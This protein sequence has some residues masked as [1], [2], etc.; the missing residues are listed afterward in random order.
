M[1]IHR[2]ALRNYRGVV[3]C[4]IPFVGDGVT[5]VEG[6]NEIGKTSLTEAF[7][8]ALE[9]PDSSKDAR[10][11][12]TQP[13]GQD[14]GP[15]VEIE[16][17][18][19]NYE[20]KLRKRWCRRTETTL[21]ITSPRHE[22]LTG[23]DAHQRLR[24]ILDETLDWGLWEALRVAQGVKLT[25]PALGVASLGAALDH[26]ATDDSA[27]AAQ[28]ALWE[29]IC[30]ERLRY[31]TPTGLKTKERQDSSADIQEARGR[32]DDLE[33][34]LRQIERDAEES[35]RLAQRHD[36][37]QND[38]DTVR[39]S[40][41]ELAERWQLIEELR[42]VADERAA[43][44]GEAQSERNARNAAFERRAELVSDLNGKEEKLAAIRRERQA[45]APALEDAER[46][47]NA[48]KEDE[49]EARA[50]LDVAEQAHTRACEDRDHHRRMIEVAQFRERLG[51]IEEAQNQ[52]ARAES[53]LESIRVDSDL[54]EQIGQAHIAVVRAEASVE[55]AA[56]HVTTTAIRSV[57]IT[58]D[59][60]EYGLQAG[61][62]HDLTVSDATEFGIDDRATVLVR[63]GAGSAETAQR[64]D[65]ARRELRRL[66][67]Q[68]DVT[69]LASAQTAERRRSSAERDR[70]D[71]RTAIRDNLRDL[72]YEELARM[73]DRHDRRI[74]EYATRRYPL[75]A[76]PDDLRAA[77]AL[78]TASEAQVEEC[79]SV[80]EASRGRVQRASEALANVQLQA[81]E[82][83]GELKALQDARDAASA[84]LSEARRPISDEDLASALATAE[85]S[86]EL[87]AEAADAALENLQWEEPDSVEAQLANARGSSRNLGEQ[88][89]SNDINHSELRGSLK[90][91][92]EM[93]LSGKRDDAESELRGLEREHD[94]AE[95]KALAAQCLH[96]VFDARWRE[97]RQKYLTPFREGIERL[98]RI[99]FNPTFEVE[100]N[101]DLGIARRTLDGATLD[102]SQLSTGAREQLGIIARLA[103]AAIVSP[104]GGGAPVILDDALGWSDPSR[105]QRM[106]A[107]IAAAGND[108]QVIILTCTPGRYAYVG[109]ATVV[110]LPTS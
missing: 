107:A 65:E 48:A 85:E 34:S 109:N 71:A 35:A 22:Q 31:W 11:K 1:R 83:A 43:E 64:L 67:D 94:S 74:E 14:V 20:L 105:L 16:I 91:R 99:V 82:L 27:S 90:T 59:E 50:A 13:V 57:I 98:G 37:I 38:L 96:Q 101:D 77:L 61:K 41:S 45:A 32:L 25:L 3:D 23:R 86:L 60:V 97:A 52:L 110:R 2:I 75:P 53:D 92:G 44:R 54:V 12:A 106:G 33:E 102:V 68:G 9:K 62:Q 36:Q 15:E 28:D 7:D 4:S 104:D 46:H 78:V 24:S 21:E 80:A 42:R 6:A 93:G 19:G 17:S 56:A 66:C 84:F 55:G 95:R 8:L 103:C 18:S 72:T 47:A 76:L 87:A 26:E 79:R 58:V 89:H 51:R 70:N 73:A 100:L 40:E 5:I 81:A 30:A 108:C 88:L 39:Q 63:A 49:S 69:D 29:R 10:I